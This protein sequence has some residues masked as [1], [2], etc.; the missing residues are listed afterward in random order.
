MDGATRRLQL[1]D[2]EDTPSK[3]V[4]TETRAPEAVKPEGAD[5]SDVVMGD[6]TPAM[7]DSKGDKAAE[8]ASFWAGLGGGAAPAEV[9]RLLKSLAFF[10]ECLYYPPGARVQ[11]RCGMH[12][13]W[14]RSPITWAAPFVI[15][16]DESPCRFMG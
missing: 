16:T 6:G 13:M 11:Y 14:G 2:A 8:A 10:G 15:P 7:G 5:K 3:R 9:C 12:T 4:K 1:D